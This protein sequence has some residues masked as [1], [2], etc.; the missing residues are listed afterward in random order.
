MVTHAP[1]GVLSRTGVGLGGEVER[2]KRSQITAHNANAYQRRV[3]AKEASGTGPAACDAPPT[4][5]Q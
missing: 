5:R 1:S 4:G 2:P 3:A